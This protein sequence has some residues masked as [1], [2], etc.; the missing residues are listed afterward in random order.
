MPYSFKWTV[1]VGNTDFSGLVYTPEIIDCIV[2]GYEKMMEAIDYSP[3]QAKADGIVY[4]V[5]HIEAD[6]HGP[7]N[8]EDT[9]LADFHPRVGTSS[10]TLDVTG[11]VEGEQVFSGELTSVFVHTDRLESVPILETVRENVQ[12]YVDR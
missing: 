4:P 7:V 12:Q 11:A 9:V 1:R 10:I 3:T 8:L 5:V 2:Q 6:Y